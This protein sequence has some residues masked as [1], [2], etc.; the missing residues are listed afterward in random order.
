M[1]PP[2]TSLALKSAEELYRVEPPLPL[3]E[4]PRQQNKGN[5]DKPARRQR[6]PTT[7][8]QERVAP[9]AAH[10]PRQPRRQ[11]RASV[12][13][14]QPPAASPGASDYDRRRASSSSSPSSLARDDDFLSRRDLLVWGGRVAIVAALSA[15][16]AIAWQVL[17]HRENRHVSSASLRTPVQ[18]SGHVG[19]VQ[20]LS[21]SPDG[22]LLASAAKDDAN[23][24]LWDIAQ[25]LS[26]HSMLTSSNASH[27]VA[28]ISW[29]RDSRFLLSSVTGSSGEIWNAETGNII[30]HIPFEIDLGYWHPQLDIATFVSPTEKGANGKAILIWDIASA[31]LLATLSDVSNVITALA[32]S[33]ITTPTLVAGAKDGVITFWK[34]AAGSSISKSLPDLTS[35]TDAITALSWEPT[36]NRFLSA[37]ADGTA[38]RWNKDQNTVIQHGKGAVTAVAW[39]PA[40]ALV[41]VGLA[42]GELLLF[43]S[44][45][46]NKLAGIST[47]ARIGALIWS[48]NG[49]SLASGGDDK[50]VRVYGLQTP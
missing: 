19:P 22:A 46:G 34:G 48:P 43:D 8:E 40:L 31:S 11:Q 47:D 24:Y 9:P 13:P 5:Q 3:A 32:W 16:G 45:N 17:S 23:V 15:G 44:D 25:P 14:Y 29:A 28:T 49:R 33:P 12:P 27:G 20:S 37:S 18:L 50:S 6:R 30:A 36:G 39:N 41:A 7:Q 1:P 35:H 4:P 2:P 42:D 38:R 10:E 21:W 26:P